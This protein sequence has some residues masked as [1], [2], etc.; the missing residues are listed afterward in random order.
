MWKNKSELDEDKIYNIYRTTKNIEQQ[1]KSQEMLLNTD[2]IQ[3]QQ[4]EDPDLLTTSI[5]S[6]PKQRS[7]RRLTLSNINKRIIR[8]KWFKQFFD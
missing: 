2:I 6:I 1:K 3:Q 5:N 4:D 8:K 7:R